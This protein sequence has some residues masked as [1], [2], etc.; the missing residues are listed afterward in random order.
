MLLPAT[1]AAVRGYDSTWIWAHR[2]A[3]LTLRQ[4]GLQDQRMRNIENIFGLNESL[5]L[6]QNIPI[7]S[8]FC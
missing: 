8:Q 1:A 7:H 6:P 2:V 3:I 4:G 5:W